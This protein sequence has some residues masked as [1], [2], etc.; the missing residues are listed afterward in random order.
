M[1][2]VFIGVGSNLGFREQTLTKAR[3]LLSHLLKVRFL[4]NS[5]VYETDPVGG[6]P[7]Q[8]KFL[9]AVWEIETDLTPQ[10]LLY[11]LQT[12]ERTLGRERK[13]VNGPRTID[14]DI[15]FYDDLHLEEPGLVIPHPRLH[16][17]W[18]VLKP[19]WDLAAEFIH[20]VTGKSV[21][22]LLD[23]V[24]KPKSAFSDRHCEEVEDRR[25]NP[26]T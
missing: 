16:E 26:R 25:S 6:P 17:R 15:L 23:E 8:R 14:L 3:I 4:R 1:K 5:A 11:E 7:G 18:F 2:R 12:I 22:E 10:Q 19:L 9:N 20:P 13:E 21:C 24:T